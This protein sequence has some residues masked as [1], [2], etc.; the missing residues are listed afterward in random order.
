MH[1]PRFISRLRGGL[2]LAALAGGL[3]L[4]PVTAQ[5]QQISGPATPGPEVTAV[6]QH[7]GPPGVRT[8]RHP[9]MARVRGHDAKGRPLLAA[10]APGGYTAAQLRAATG[11]KGTGKGQTVAVVDAFNDPYALEDLNTY[12]AQMGLPGVCTRKKQKNCFSFTQVQPDGIGGYDPGWGMESSLD[13][14]MVHA[15]APDAHIVLVEAYDNSVDAMFQA[16]DHA[17][18]LGA[19]TISNSWGVDGEADDETTYDR[20][21]DLDDSVCVFSAG[22]SGNPGGYPAYNPHVLAVGGTELSLGR[23]GNVLG[24][25]AWSLGGGGISQYEPRPAYQD[26]VNSDEHRGIPDVSFDADPDSG[27]AVY[28]TGANGWVEVGGTS[29][30]AP[31]WAGI[32]AAADQLRAAAGKPALTS[33]DDQTQKAVYGLKSGLADVTTGGNGSCGA[34][35]TAGPGYDFVTGLGSPR[36]GIDTALAAAP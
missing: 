27:V 16:L 22:D 29:A 15:L 25:T 35:C 20:H 36:A 28:F 23:A 33:A 30:G 9:L 4:S 24:E 11:L 17:A 26:Q 2:A 8:V 13:V 6:P 31:A 1:P 3:C 19:P 34:V 7:A 18:S 10:G 12:S 21:C 14:Q 32:L 5:A